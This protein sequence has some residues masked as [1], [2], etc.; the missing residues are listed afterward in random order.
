MR[1]QNLK[2]KLFG[3]IFKSIPALAMIMVVINANSVASPINGQPVPPEDLKKY[4]KF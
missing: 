3:V 1:K 2:E 4:R